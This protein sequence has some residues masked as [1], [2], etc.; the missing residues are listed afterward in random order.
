MVELM[1]PGPATCYPIATVIFIQL[2][3]VPETRP[4]EVLQTKRRLGRPVGQPPEEL[5][6]LRH[7]AGGVPGLERQP[8][9]PVPS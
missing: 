6:V 1:K 4:G 8:P 3:Q 2:M 5:P 7:R 9:L